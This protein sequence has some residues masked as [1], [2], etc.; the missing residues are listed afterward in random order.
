MP[1][2]SATV[3]AKA[4]ATTTA[5]LRASRRVDGL[6]LCW[7]TSTTYDAPTAQPSPTQSETLPFG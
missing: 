7:L 1:A 2:A 6:R 5:R 4:A 3:P